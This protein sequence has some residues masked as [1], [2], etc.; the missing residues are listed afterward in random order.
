MEV[1]REE[2]ARLARRRKDNGVDGDGVGGEEEPFLTESEENGCGGWMGYVLDAV[3]P[4]FP[5]G[6]ALVATYRALWVPVDIYAL[7]LWISHGEGEVRGR[8]G[9]QSP[10]LLS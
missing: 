9:K 4:L 10:S 6:I 8:A 3:A 5:A 2:S 1:D 7:Y